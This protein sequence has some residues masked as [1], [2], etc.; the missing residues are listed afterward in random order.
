MAFHKFKRTLIEYC[1]V[2]LV[3]SF[4]VSCDKPMIPE[5]TSYS[6]KHFTLYYR[7]GSFSLQYIKNAGEKKER[8]LRRINN[9]Y[10][11]NYTGHIDTYLFSD[12][13]VSYYVHKDKSCYETAAY[14]TYDSGHEIIHAV[15]NQIVGDPN[16]RFFIEGAAVAGQVYMEEKNPLDYFLKRHVIDNIESDIYI[17]IGE[18]GSFSLDDY[19]YSLAGAFVYYLIH[20]YGVELFKELYRQNL[21]GN[22]D[23][24]RVIFF[25]VYGFPLNDIVKQFIA[26]CAEN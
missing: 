5:T 2:L 8:L 11:V 3:S 10:Q 17:K 23:S 20:S 22:I 26:Q 24:I 16:N 19:D 9:F 25:K 7:E 15:M 1:F 13:T 6:T 12:G 4:F 21:S 14:L 18:R